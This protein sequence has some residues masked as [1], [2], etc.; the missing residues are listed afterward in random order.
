MGLA[1]DAKLKGNEFSWL[2]TAFFVA[3]AVAEIP[4]GE[5]LIIHILPAIWTLIKTGTLLQKFP[6]PRVLG[7]NVI[8][9]GITV[10]ST[11]ACS[12]FGSLLA[13]RIILGALEAVTSPSLVLITST[14]YQRREASPRYG[15]W[16][17]GLGGGQILGGILSF[18]FQHG[19]SSSFEGWR[20]MFVVVGV[21]NMLIGVAVVFCLPSNPQEAKFLSSEEKSVV[22]ARLAVNQTGVDKSETLAKPSQILDAFRDAQVWLLCLITVLCS[23]PSGVITTYSA[24]LIR[25]FGYTSKQ[26]ALLNIPSGVVSILSTM[27]ATIAVGR[28]YARWVSIGVLVVPVIIGGALMSFLPIKNQ[29]GLLTGIYLINCV[30]PI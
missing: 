26:S 25:N 2:A 13:V 28:G 21:V 27:F 20:M 8:L 22:L 10:A 17:C 11:A 9:W 30:S 5:L 3:F 24:T 14:W 19:T 15:V 16:Y 18:T 7:I 12:S 29:G 23:L 4:Q 6:V 1:K